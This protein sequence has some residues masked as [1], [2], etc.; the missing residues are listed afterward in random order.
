MRSMRTATKTQVLPT[1]SVH[2]R[3]LQSPCSTTS[4][5][6]GSFLLPGPGWLYLS[7]HSLLLTNLSKSKFLLSY[8]VALKLEN[9]LA[10]QLLETD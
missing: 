5:A 1:A 10:F 3:A 4:S 7:T 2:R 8:S 6:I 9:F